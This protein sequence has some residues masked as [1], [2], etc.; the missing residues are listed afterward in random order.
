MAGSRLYELA[1]RFKKAAL[2]KHLYDFDLFAVRLSDGGYAYC[3]VI[4]ADGDFFALFVYPGAAG[5]ASCRRQCSLAVFEPDREP[6]FSSRC[7][8][9]CFMDKD[10]MQPREYAQLRAYTQAHGL[11][12]RGKNAFPRFLSFVPG[13]LPTLQLTEA[14]EA[15]LCAGL[16]AGLAIATALRDGSET[17]LRFNGCAAGDSVPLVTLSPEGPALSTLILP[18]DEAPDWPEPPLEN[19]VTFLRLARLRRHGILE[20]RV[21]VLP[22]PIPDEKDTHKPPFFPTALLA[23]YPD[24]LSPLPILPVRDYPEQAGLLLERLAGVLLE[25]ETCPGFIHVSDDRTEKLLTRFCDR[26]GIQLKRVASL[27]AVD[28]FFDAILEM[29]PEIGESWD[30]EDFSVIYMLRDLLEADLPPEEAKALFYSFAQQLDSDVEEDEARMQLFQELAEQLSE[31]S[32]QER[33]RAGEL[34]PFP[35][36][37]TQ[38]SEPEHDSG[39]APGTAH[40]SSDSGEP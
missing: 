23:A 1:F 27:P 35:L 24:G 15:C 14:E 2:W 5:L 21:V 36:Q 29:L 13:R 20:C 26:L 17:P 39:Q 30:S 11:R 4:G 37:R 34:I 33:G 32:G 8:M 9:C 38:E 22:C 7:L 31:D 18:P 25:D 3:R 40:R 16:E 12:P 19:D 6:E 10:E 28:A